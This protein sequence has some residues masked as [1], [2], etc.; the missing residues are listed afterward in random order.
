MRINPSNSLLPEV[1]RGKLIQISVD[2]KPIDAYEGETVAAALLSAGI[3][4]FRRDAHTNEPRG[5]Y[6]GMGLCY[7]CLVTVDGAHAVRACVTPIAA[8]MRIETCK[9]MEL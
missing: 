1:Q 2:G 6:C 5:I 8:G 3:R 4:A 9:E 7:E